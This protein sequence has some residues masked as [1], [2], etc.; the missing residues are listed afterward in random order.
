MNNTPTEYQIGKGQN[1]STRSIPFTTGFEEA[2][3]V[4]FG[5]LFPLKRREAYRQY[6]DRASTGKTFKITQEACEDE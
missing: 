1:W 6:S 2:D 4:E 3:L 5:M